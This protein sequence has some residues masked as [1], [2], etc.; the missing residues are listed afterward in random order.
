MSSCFYVL[1]PLNTEKC[2]IHCNFSNQ[3]TCANKGVHPSSCKRAEQT[4][5]P[6]PKSKNWSPLS[7]LPAGNPK[8]NIKVNWRKKNF[9]PSNQH[10][11]IMNEPLVHNLQQHLHL[12][13]SFQGWPQECQDQLFLHVWLHPWRKM[14]CLKFQPTSS[15]HAEYPIV[16]QQ[17]KFLHCWSHSGLW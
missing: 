13:Y 10:T 5:F 9:I 7:L 11:G 8:T 2:Y 3:D 17:Q 4:N 6:C 15:Y 16:L 1:R 14:K 12:S